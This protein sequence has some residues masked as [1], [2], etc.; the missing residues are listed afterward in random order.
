M[1]NCL[2]GFIRNW[3]LQILFY[4]QSH[5][6][7]LSFSSKCNE[8]KMDSQRILNVSLLFGYILLLALIAIASTI[9]HFV[10]LKG[11]KNVLDVPAVEKKI[12]AEIQKQP[13]DEVPK[14]SPDRGGV[15]LHKNPFYASK[16][17]VF[18]FL[19]L[20]KPQKS[21]SDNSKYS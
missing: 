7:T 16:L 15:H 18:L 2:P 3:K 6:S 9:V 21:S 5:I 19:E 13:L 20:E 17:R 8:K 1:N 4:F 10:C 12:N 11:H 14:Q